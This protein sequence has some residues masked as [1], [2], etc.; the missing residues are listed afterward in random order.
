MYALKAQLKNGRL[1][2]DEPT[3]LPDGAALEVVVLVEAHH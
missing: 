1:I 3:D 2:V